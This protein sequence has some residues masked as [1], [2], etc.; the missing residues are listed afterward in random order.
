MKAMCIAVLSRS[1]NLYSTKRIVEE[2][3]ATGNKPMVIDYT[4]C[5][6]LIE[7]GN[8]LIIYRGVPLKNVNAVIPRIASS[9]VVHGSAVVRQFEMAGIY[10]V[11]ESQAIVRSKDKLRTLQLLSRANIPIP[12]T[13]FAKFPKPKDISEILKTIGNPPYIIKFVY[14][15]HGTG[16]I[17]AETR[18]SAISMIEALSNVKVNILIQEFVKESYGKDVRAFVVGDR[19]VAAMERQARGG[20][21]RA[22]IHKGGKGKP[23]TLSSEEEALAVKSAKVIGLNVAGVDML[24]TKDGYKVVEINSSPGL[25]GIEEVTGKN[26]AREI[27][28]FTIRQVLI[29]ASTR[30]KIQI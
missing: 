25:R 21:F 26:I 17:L 29:G 13:I 28:D 20:E 3:K 15:T 9:H 18:E 19:V 24:I 30:D 1:E 2:I 11:C 7:S 12:R 5:S 22:N 10:S 14:G 16:T 6:I 23:I 4:R 27:V 8:P